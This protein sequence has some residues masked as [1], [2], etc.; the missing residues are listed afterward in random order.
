[1]A[2][3]ALAGRTSFGCLAF[4]T[5]HSCHHHLLGHLR[6]APSSVV[7]SRFCRLNVTCGSTNLGQAAS[8]GLPLMSAGEESQ[9]PSTSG[10]TWAD[11]ALQGPRPEMEDAVV[12][13]VDALNGFNYAAVFDG[14]AGFSSVKFLREELYREC[15]GALQN[16][17]LLE[18]NDF[19]IIEKAITSAFVQADS[20]LLSW[21]EETGNELESGSTATVMFLGSDSL[22]VAHVGDSRAVISRAGKAEVVCG[23]HRPYGNSKTS[24]AEIKRIRQAGGWINNGR[25]CGFLSVSRAFGDIKLKTRR[26][27]ML[28]EGVKGGLWTNKFA[29]R[30]EMNGDWVTAAP[31]ITRTSLKDAEFIILASDGLWDYVQSSEAVRIVRNQLRQHGDAQR[32]CEVLANLALDKNGEDNVSIVIA[33]FRKV[34]QQPHG[35]FEE[36]N[37]GSEVGQAVLTLGIVGLGVWLSQFASQNGL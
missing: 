2:I 17:L 7:S 23:D 10:I 26:Q 13:R 12:V 14:H 24:L 3:P 35:S 30:I 29:S 19:S 36:Q 11:I 15:T 22:I 6:N 5:N 28:D 8:V 37:I 4:A 27:E 25:V 1:M 16:G 31:E 32:A 33:D 9:I 18:S 34:Q 21:L 20:R